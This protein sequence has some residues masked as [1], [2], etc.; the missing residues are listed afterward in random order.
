MLAG[1][2]E[3]NPFDTQNVGIAVLSLGGIVVSRSL[4]VAGDEMDEDIIQYARQ[5]YNLLIGERMAERVK[6]NQPNGRPIEGEAVPPRVSATILRAEI[7]R[8]HLASV[9]CPCVAAWP[10]EPCR[11]RRVE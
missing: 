8:P 11:W 1:I 6:I 9:K 10:V 2:Y 7:C 4:R 5:K 3:L